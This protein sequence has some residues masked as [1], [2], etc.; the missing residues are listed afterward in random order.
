MLGVVEPLD[1]VRNGNV[2]L[3]VA[4]T[5][6]KVVADLIEL[7]VLQTQLELEKPLLQSQAMH[8]KV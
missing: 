3:G 4:E 2:S 5:L 7:V 1:D 8:A 6:G